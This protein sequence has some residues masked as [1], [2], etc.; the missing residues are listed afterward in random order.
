M[1]DVTERAPNRVVANATRILNTIAV[2]GPQTIAE[3]SETL[4]IPRSSVYRIIESLESLR[5]AWIDPLGR[6]H[7]GTRLLYLGERA[8]QGI[9]EVREA[10]LILDELK[11]ATGHTVYLCQLRAQRTTCLDWRQGDKIGLPVLRPGM[12]LPDHA[13]AATLVHLAYDRSYEEYVLSRDDFEALTAHTPTSARTLAEV[14][15]ATR[16]AGYSL[17][18]QDV[19]LGVA[20]IGMPIFD[21][22][23]SLRGSLSVAGLRGDI[24]ESTDVIVDA[25]RAGVGLLATRLATSRVLAP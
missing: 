8:K 16:N 13:S 17:S 5:M 14:I 11:R 25:L 4:E 1:A 2:D 12:M 3:I 9:V 21:Q 18:D 24:L 7:L 20:A 22:V 19:T 10:R 6:V 23:G 15:L